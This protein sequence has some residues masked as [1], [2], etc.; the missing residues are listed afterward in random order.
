MAAARNSDEYEPTMMPTS[1]ARANSRRA[2]APSA[3]EPTMSSDNTGSAEVTLV[4]IERMATRLRAR[5][6][7][8]V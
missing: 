3:T 8:S 6:I 5:F 4:L 2:V 1:R 7:N